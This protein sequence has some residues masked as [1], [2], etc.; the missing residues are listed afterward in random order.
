[1]DANILILRCSKSNFSDAC[2]SSNHN[3]QLLMT[4]Q[5]KIQSKN[6]INVNKKNLAFMTT[7]TKYQKWVYQVALKGV[8][9]SK[10]H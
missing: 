6:K 3:K 5:K 10:A 4:H 7:A 1:M 9:H 8:Q 2:A